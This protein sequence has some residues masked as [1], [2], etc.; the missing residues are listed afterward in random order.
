MGGSFRARE[1][2]FYFPLTFLANAGSRRRRHLQAPATAADQAYLAGELIRAGS[3]VITVDAAKNGGPW[4][5]AQLDLTICR[6]LLAGR[7]WSGEVN[8]SLGVPASYQDVPWAAAPCACC[9]LA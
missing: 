4:A 9:E 6:R 5:V 8:L 7:I 3:S 1:E 2:S